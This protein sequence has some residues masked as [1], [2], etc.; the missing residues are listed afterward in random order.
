[1]A[2]SSPKMRQNTLFRVSNLKIFPGEGPRT[3]YG[4]V[5]SPHPY[6][7][8]PPHQLCVEGAEAPCYIALTAT[9]FHSPPT[10]KFGENPAFSANQNNSKFSGP[11]DE[12]EK[13]DAFFPAQK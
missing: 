12:R 5:P 11:I 13:S 3:P 1:M 7:P 6:P 10:S 8:P 4:R 2:Q 9:Q